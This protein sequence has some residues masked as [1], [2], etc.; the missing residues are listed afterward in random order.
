M[1]SDQTLDDIKK[2]VEN[3]KVN[4]LEM[5]CYQGPPSKNW[6]KTEGRFWEGWNKALDKV[7]DSIDKQ[8]KRTG[9]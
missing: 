4:V 3:T 5:F 8:T 7:L 1:M 6:L 2:I 9:E